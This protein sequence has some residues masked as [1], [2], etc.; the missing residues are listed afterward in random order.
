[1]T[2]ARALAD[3]SDGNGLVLVPSRI[4]HDAV[5][6]LQQAGFEVASTD[7]VGRARARATKSDAAVAS[8][9]AVQRAAVRG[10]ATARVVLR[11]TT[12]AGSDSDAGSDFDTTETLHW[13][14]AVLTTTRLR[15]VVDAALAGVGVDRAAN[16]VV[17][18]GPADEEPPGVQ[19]G[20]GRS[21]QAG[22]PLRAGRPIAIDVAPRGPAGY[23]GDCAWTVVVGGYGGWARRAAVAVEAARRAALTHVTPGASVATVQRELLAELSAYGFEGTDGTDCGVVHGVGLAHH[24]RPSSTDRAVEDGVLARGSTIALGPTVS[25]PEHGTVTL[26]DVVVVTDPGPEILAGSPTGLAP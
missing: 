10:L 6:Y 21:A 14:G 13:R 9:R 2:A 12:A 19:R 23:Y 25:D 20:D 26:E 4:P 15:R 7:A 17:D 16:T 24:E 1:V 3:G 11:E 18:A 5:V 22:Q 8:L